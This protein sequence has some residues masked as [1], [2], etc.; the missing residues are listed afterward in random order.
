MIDSSTLQFLQE[1]N[2]NNHKEWFSDH[3]KWY[4]ISREN[5]IAFCDTLLTDLKTIQ[6]DLQNTQVKNCI[7]RINRDIRFSKNKDPYKNYFAAG[8]GPGGRTS[9]RVDFYLQ[10][11][12]DNSFLGAGM[13]QPSPKNLALF[14]Q[15]IDYNPQ[16]LKGIIYDPK[17]TAYFPEIHG[18]VLKTKPKGYDIDHPD[19]ELLKRKELFFSH[20]YTDK[21][22]ISKN[23]N[24]SVFEGCTIIKPYQDYLNHLFYDTDEDN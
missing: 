12:P 19:I 11:Q 21:E 20:S 17:F 5:F 6:A 13:W 10:I 7:L 24:Q 14:R 8:F 23:F 1:L 15:E 16:E 9:G 22:V 4:D 2:K 3:R 18:E